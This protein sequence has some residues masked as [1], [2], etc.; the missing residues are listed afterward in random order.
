MLAITTQSEVS[1]VAWW[2]A[3]V[4]VKGEILDGI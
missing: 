2:A 3:L 1:V 4:Y